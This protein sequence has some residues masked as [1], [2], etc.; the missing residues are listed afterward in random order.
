MPR[1]PVVDVRIPVF[2]KCPENSMHFEF[3]CTHASKNVSTEISIY[4]KHC[5]K[6]TGA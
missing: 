1:T 2:T 4:I 5:P 3:Y 6:E